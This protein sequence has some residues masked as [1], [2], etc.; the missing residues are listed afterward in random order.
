[1]L[2]LAMAAMMSFVLAGTA[3]AY[4]YGALLEQDATAVAVGGDGG[5]GGDATNVG[6]I[7]QE[8]EFEQE[9]DAEVNQANVIDDSAI[10]GGGDQTNVAVIDQDQEANDVTQV[11]AAELDQDADGG[12]GGDGGDAAAIAA[13]LFLFGF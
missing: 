7:K 1:M 9:Q 11:N 12:D 6:V 10:A 4:D 8:N 2:A 13:N 5:D 3:F